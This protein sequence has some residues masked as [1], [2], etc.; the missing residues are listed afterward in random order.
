MICTPRRTLLGHPMEEID[1]AC[2]ADGGEGNIIQI[3]WWGNLK[4]INEDLGVDRKIILKET[5]NE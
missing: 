2:L 4:K 3:F 1:W 5:L